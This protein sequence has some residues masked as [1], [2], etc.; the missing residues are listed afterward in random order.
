M[1]EEEHE[2]NI[3]LSKKEWTFCPSCGFKLPEI[4]R[5]KFCIK[6]G[7]DLEYIKSNV[8]SHQPSPPYLSTYLYRSEGDQKKIAD[9][10]ILNLGEKQLW[11]S[12]YSIGI[13]ILAFILMIS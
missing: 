10:D 8:I 4:D 11:G 2:E 13:P 1:N 3:F 6:C 7:V 9:E 5:Q 12:F